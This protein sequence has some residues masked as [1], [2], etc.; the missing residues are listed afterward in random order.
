MILDLGLPDADGI[1]VIRRLRTWTELPVI[2]LLA[3]DDRAARITALDAGAGDYVNKQFAMDELLARMRA[4]LRRVTPARADGPIL[5][6]DKLE[7]DL[8]RTRATISGEPLRL[9]P[10]EW[11]LLEAFV[12]NPGKLLT[13]HW[14]LR[15]LWG[16]ATRWIRATTSGSTSVS[17][18]SG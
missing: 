6:F 15:R 11:A 5:R 17:S 13:H 3:R 8:E 4:T 18:V 2:V 9:T 7:V 1:D 12:T 14:I 10:T 16:R